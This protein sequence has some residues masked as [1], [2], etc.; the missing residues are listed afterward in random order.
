MTFGK[1]ERRAIIAEFNGGEISSDAGLMLIRKIDQHYGFSQQIAACFTD[2]RDPSRVEHSIE[3]MVAQ[4]LYGLVQG[5]EDLNDHE[6]LRVDVLLGLAV[7]KLERQR[8]EGA[9]LAGKSTL[10]RLEQSYRRDDSAAVNPRYVKTRVDP[11]QLEAVL[12]NL[13]FAQ[14]P[15]PPKRLILDMDVTDDTTYGE[16]EGAD[17]N[18]YYQSTCYTPLY[19]FCGRQLLVSRLRPANVDPAAGALEELQ[20]IIPAIQAQW[21]GVR[22][23]V[24]GDSA[25]SRDDIMTWCEATANVDYVVAQGSNAVLGRLSTRWAERATAD[26]QQ[27]RQQASETLAAHLSPDGPSLKDLDALVPE[28]THY[29]CFTYQTQDSWS[30][31]RRVICKVTA[32]A[33]GLR[34]HFVV[35]SLS[36]QYASSQRLHADYYCPRGEMENRLK[37]QQL[38]LFSDRTSNHYFDDNQL[39]LWFSAFAYGLLNALRQQ[40]LQHTALAN[41]RVGTIRSQLLKV[42]ALIRISVRRIHV[43]MHTAFPHRFLFQQ[44]YQR[45]MTLPSAA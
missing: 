7:G 25:Y 2:H 15:T 45:L 44:V 13:F 31:S 17:F 28:A 10:N 11:V 34:H 41:A 38:D 5:Y 18:G 40:A 21:P 19:I 42:G 3:A 33:K 37:E 43:V 30:C 23:L 35:T 39:R 26:Y 14:H 24:R 22:I 1:L 4:R 6:T 29:G 27:R 32:G 8:G 9:P 16:Q 12:L 36:A 20:R